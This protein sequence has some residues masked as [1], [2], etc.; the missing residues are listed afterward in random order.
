MVDTNLL[1]D[2]TRREVM[3]ERK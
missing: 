3:S 2:A 1:Q